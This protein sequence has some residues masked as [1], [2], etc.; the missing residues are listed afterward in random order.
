MIESFDGSFHNHFR[1][2]EDD[3][4]GCTTSKSICYCFTIILSIWRSKYE[5]FLICVI[6][7]GHL[8]WIKSLGQF[9][10]NTHWRAES[11]KYIVNYW[12]RSMKIP[13]ENMTQRCL[14][15]PAKDGVLGCFIGKLNWNPTAMRKLRRNIAGFSWGNELR[16]NSS[17]KMKQQ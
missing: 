3:Q 8:N 17:T 2:I 14:I 11:N 7:W 1:T 10:V 15:F 4:V 6:K 16:S 12:K 13:T 5:I 9:E